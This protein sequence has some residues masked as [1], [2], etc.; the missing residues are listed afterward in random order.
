MEKTT[1]PGTV[2]VGA[3]FNAS[4]F[5]VSDAAHLPGLGALALFMLDPLRKRFGPATIHSGYRSASYNS[6]V[7]G[8]PDSRHVY[9]RHPLTPAADV[10]FANGT[11]SQWSKLARE[12]AF[13]YGFGGVGTY[14]THVHVDLGPRR[15]W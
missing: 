11:P 6:K 13:I 1:E 3:Y 10:S 9:D 7:G 8:A 12:L 2:R 14:G 5:K 4:E 15:V